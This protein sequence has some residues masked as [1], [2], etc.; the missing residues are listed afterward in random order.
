MVTPRLDHRNLVSGNMVHHQIPTETTTTTTT[1]VGK[2]G[3]CNTYDFVPEFTRNRVA[4]WYSVGLR[5][6]LSG[7]RVPAEVRN[8]SLHHCVQIG[9]PTQPPIQW[10]PGSLSLGA[11]VAG[12]MKLTTHLHPKFVELYFRSPSTPPWRGVEL[13][14]HRDNFT[15]LPLIAQ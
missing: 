6:E 12:V 5:A 7:V 1:T 9:R 13:K 2:D 11:I 3:R 10:G 8:F 15:F 4:Q 14:S